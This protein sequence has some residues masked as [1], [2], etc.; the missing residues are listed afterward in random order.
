MNT[1]DEIIQTKAYSDLTSSELEVIRELVSSEEEYNEMKSFYANIDQLAITEREEVPASVKTSLNSVFQAKHPGISQNWNAPAEA[2][3]EKKIVPL[4]NRTLFRAAALLV[5]SAGAATIW[6]A[7]PENKEIG[8]NQTELTASS[9]SSPFTKAKEQKESA[10]TDKEEFPINTGE[11]SSREFTAAAEVP[12]DELADQQNEE[13]AF[14]K[15]VTTTK[16]TLAEKSAEQ[17]SVGNYSASPSSP[18]TSYSFNTNKALKEDTKDKG[19][20]FTTAGMDADLNP[21]GFGRIYQKEARAKQAE[22]GISTTDLLSLI[23]PSF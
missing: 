9:D 17:S 3:E 7:L 2:V 13:I 19:N 20:S 5:L 18:I 12:I 21:D 8:K 10:T 14:E 15:E 6:F 23:E 1:F 4:Y 16:W 11:E 22:S